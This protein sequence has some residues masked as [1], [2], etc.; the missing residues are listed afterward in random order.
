MNDEKLE[1]PKWK[2]HAKLDAVVVN[3]PAEEMAL[4]DG[5][6]DSPAAFLGND[7]GSPELLPEDPDAAESARAERIDGRCRCGKYT[8][9][10]AERKGHVCTEA[11]SS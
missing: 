11:A 5:W 7:P 8:L 10:N 3:D 2:Y 6:E 4:G 1:F 9:V